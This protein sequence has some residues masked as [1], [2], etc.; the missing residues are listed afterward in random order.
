MASTN[1]QKYLDFKPYKPKKGE[2]YMS[3]QQTEHFKN[4]LFSWKKMLMSEA[5]KTMDHMKQD[6]SKLSDPNDAATQEEEFRL[7][8]RTRDRERKLISKIDQALNRI[9]DGSYGYCED[10]GEPIGIKRLEA[11]PIATLSI[12]A[13]ERHEKM[14]KTQID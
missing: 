6:S 8:L 12:E 2:E 9:D 11:R 3:P 5:E 13:Q 4:I 10:T 1:L 7:E 14:E